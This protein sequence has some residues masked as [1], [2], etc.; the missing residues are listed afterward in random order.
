[1]VKYVLV[2]YFKNGILKSLHMPMVFEM[3]VFEIPKFPWH[4]LLYTQYSNITRCWDRENC[5]KIYLYVTTC[6]KWPW[7]TF[8]FSFE[9]YAATTLIS[10]GE[11]FPFSRFWGSFLCPVSLLQ[12][13]L[14]VLSDMV[15]NIRAKNGNFVTFNQEI[16]VLVKIRYSKCIIC[17]FQHCYLVIGPDDC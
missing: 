5:T 11:W 10:R 12:R 17:Q 6:S 15:Y 14:R 2:L 4:W 7:P 9:K 8:K 3:L 13:H 1:M 16:I